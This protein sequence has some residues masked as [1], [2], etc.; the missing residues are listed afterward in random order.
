MIGGNHRYFDRSPLDVQRNRSESNAALRF[1]IG[2][3]L[4]LEYRQPSLG[5]SP[6]LDVSF[7]LVERLSCFINRVVTILQHKPATL[8]RT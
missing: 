5:Q 8:S 2:S 1:F 3:E 6:K 4:V 7:R